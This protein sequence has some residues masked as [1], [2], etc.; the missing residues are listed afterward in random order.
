MKYLLLLIM[1]LVACGKPAPSVPPDILA[2][3]QAPANKVLNFSYDVDWSAVRE[4]DRHTTKMKPGDTVLIYIS[5]NG[6]DVDAAEAIISRM[7]RFKTICV[8][9][10]AASAAFEIYQHCTVRVFRENTVLM[11]HHHYMVFTT[12]VAITTPELLVQS[13]K[14]FSQEYG[15]LSR[16]A[17]RMY[18][19]YE[20]LVQKIAKNGGEWYL[21]G[22]KEIKKAHAGDYHI[23]DNE[24][25]K[26]L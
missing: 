15:L 8:A 19:T 16:C 25:K 21:S 7:T 4:F 9:D 26:A 6:G 13:I 20:E 14:A 12:R 2:E 11:V 1:F 17:A 24:L 5:S 18:M 10:F 23:K 22:P 3:M